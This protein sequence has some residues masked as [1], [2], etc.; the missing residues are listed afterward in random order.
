M[1]FRTF[2]IYWKSRIS[3]YF[4][5]SVAYLFLPLNTI[6]R[7]IYGFRSV[8]D[9]IIGIAFLNVIAIL[10]FRISNLKL[11]RRHFVFLIGMNFVYG[12]SVLAQLLFPNDATA[13][14]RQIVFN[15][16]LVIIGTLAYFIFLNERHIIQEQSRITLYA[17]RIFVVFFI[18]V[19]SVRLIAILVEITGFSVQFIGI[20]SNFMPHL[21]FAFSTFVLYLSFFRP[22]FLLFSHQQVYRAL[23][24]AWITQKLQKT[25]E[26]KFETK[27]STDEIIA[28]LHRVSG[29][30]RTEMDT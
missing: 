27:T 29:I 9:S 5:L 30:V 2:Q 3:D 12:S 7:A 25:E 4:I 23:Q 22:E 20:V 28:Y 17:W 13:L 21:I 14:V 26:E 15:M 11:Q 10:L 6:F 19:G 18:V 1:A 8:Q 16:L 24:T